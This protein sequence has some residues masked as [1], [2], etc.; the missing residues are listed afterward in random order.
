MHRAGRE[1]LQNQPCKSALS[2]G[3]YNAKE[4]L[5]AITRAVSPTLNRC[6]LTHIAR[7]PIDLARA[8][9][10]HHAYQQCLRDLGLRVIEL[11][12]EPDYP[13]AM[14][15]EDPV[16]VLD[17]IAVIA[18]MGARSRRG[19]AE[20]LARALEPYRLLRHLREPAT[21]DGGDVMRVGRMLYVGHSARTNGAGIQ[22][23][24]AEVE[25]FGYRVCPVEVKGCLHLK[26]GAS[27]LGGDA[28]LAHREWV[29][30]GAFHGMRVLDVPEGEEAGAN[31]LLIG[32]T[33]LVAAGFPRT[34]G[35]ICG[36]GREVR[37]LDVSELMKAESGL[38]CSSVIFV[39]EPDR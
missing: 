17:E 10:E 34:V 29:D 7:E 25:P 4:V 26:S 28:V 9:E 27:W 18:R 14:F 5:T 32:N 15:V 33:V 36:L 24:A 21:L 1:R 38:T 16:V 35:L 39:S 12:A 2:P 20:S 13:D 8:V 3:G 37:E 19:E 6:E 30:A 31:V 11:P 22:Q 23:L